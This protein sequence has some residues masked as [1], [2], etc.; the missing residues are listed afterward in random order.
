MC[1]D[2]AVLHP[3]LFEG[4]ETASY[5]Y[6]I[7]CLYDIAFTQIFAMCGHS[8]HVYF[9][10]WMFARFNNKL[11]AIHTW[12]L[13]FTGLNFDQLRK[14]TGM[15]YFTIHIILS[16]WEL[17]LP[18]INVTGDPLKKEKAIFSFCAI[19]DSVRSCFCT[20][21]VWTWGEERAYPVFHLFDVNDFQV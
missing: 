16:S 17:I 18:S 1:L 20:I 14:K 10:S 2:P 15:Y 8:L 11:L 7:A 5:L 9:L 12:N 19:R 4:K 13:N 6:L 3:T 21:R